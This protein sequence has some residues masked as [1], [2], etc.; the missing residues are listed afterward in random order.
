MTTPHLILENRPG[1]R[2]GRALSRQD[3]ATEGDA[4][5]TTMVRSG[6]SLRKDRDGIT[7]SPT[8]Y[9]DLLNWRLHHIGGC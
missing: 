4:N 9:A 1:E 6:Y 3:V 5:T 8:S 2:S 7:P